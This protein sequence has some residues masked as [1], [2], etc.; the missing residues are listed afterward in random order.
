MRRSSPD[1]RLLHVVVPARDEEALIERCLQSVQ[2]SRLHLRATAAEIAVRTTVVLDSCT[3]RTASIAARFREVDLVEVRCASVGAARRKGVEQ[4]LHR[5]SPLDAGQVWVACTDADSEVPPGW[6]AG[7]L[8]AARDGYDARVGTVI[9]DGDV[10]SPS[11]YQR[12]RARSDFS[13]GHAHVHGA[14]LGF[15]LSAYQRVGGFTDVVCHEDVVLVHAMR[16][17]GL[18]LFAGGDDPVVTSGR[19]S[20]RLRGGFA[21]YLDRLE[22][23]AG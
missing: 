2:S 10:S 1:V 13:D 17:A 4:A 23:S 22:A 3:D 19:R 5:L 14:N 21:D 9:P 11:V 16:T 6:L 18:R 8:R 20:G 15:S 12:W 7:Q